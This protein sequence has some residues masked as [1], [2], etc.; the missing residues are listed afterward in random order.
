MQK[1]DH[2]SGLSAVTDNESSGSGSPSC[3]NSSQQKLSLS[4]FKDGRRKSISKK[5]DD[6]SVVDFISE[7]T[8]AGDLFY[9]TTRGRRPPPV[10]DFRNID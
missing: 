7:R 4:D 8:Q 10:R 5:C 9:A 1:P 3:S 2:I 6:P